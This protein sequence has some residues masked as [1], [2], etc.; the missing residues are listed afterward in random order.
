VL[1]KL[2][3]PRRQ[4]DESSFIC[5]RY[6]RCRILSASGSHTVC[7]C[8]R[9]RPIIKADEM[10]VLRVRN[11]VDMTACCSRFVCRHSL[12]AQPWAPIKILVPCRDSHQKTP[13]MGEFLEAILKPLP[14][15]LLRSCDA[16]PYRIIL[17]EKVPPVARPRFEAC[18][19]L[20]NGPARP[21]PRSVVATSLLLQSRKKDLTEM[22]M[23]GSLRWTTIIALEQSPCPRSV[24]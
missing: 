10:Q 5:R 6:G 2:Y 14:G 24:L 19:A 11:F 15:K 21:G 4:N 23:R 9:A 22:P 12:I 8:K 3:R 16:H 7:K 13:E 17:H 18:E 20:R 1:T